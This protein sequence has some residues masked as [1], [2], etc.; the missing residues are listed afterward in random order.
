MLAIKTSPSVQSSKLLAELDPVPTRRAQQS[1]KRFALL[2][3]ILMLAAQTIAVQHAHGQVAEPVCVVCAFAGNDDSL[4]PVATHVSLAR[5]VQ[6]SQTLLPAV[7]AAPRGANT[8][9]NRVRAPPT[10]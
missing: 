7:V 5:A 1:V 8:R 2:A 10:L 4:L 6:T 9:S 3:A